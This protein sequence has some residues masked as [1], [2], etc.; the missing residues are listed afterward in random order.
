MAILGLVVEYNPF[1]LGHLYQLRAAKDLLQPR[2]TVAAITGNFTQRGEPA[3]VDKWTRAQMALAQGV[4]LIIEIP[5]AW[6][7]ASASTFAAGAMHLLAAAGATDIHFGSE[8]GRLPPLMAIANTLLTEPPLYRRALKGA[9][10]QGHSFA[11]A[12]GFAL[13]AADQSLD[14][15]IFKEPNNTLGIEYLRAIKE[16]NLPLRAH[17]I[18]RT[19]SYHSLDTSSPVLAATA[20]R[21]NL[22]AGGSSKG[23][24]AQALAQIQKSFKAGRGPI[25]WEQLAPA[26]FYRLRSLPMNAYA[27]WPGA[28]EGLGLRLYKMARR[29]ES[30]QQLMQMVKTRRFP[31]TRI[32]RLCTHVLL[33]LDR[34]KLNAL[35]VEMAPPYL[36]VLALN[37]GNAALRAA[38]K[39][40]SLPVIFSPKAAPAQGK[41]LQ[42]CQA[43]DIYA[44]DIYVLAWSKPGPAG[45]DYTTA[46]ITR[47]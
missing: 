47:S 33:G 10:G 30:W 5:V 29:A 17:T 27:Q 12:Q 15:A 6:A 25:A 46:L 20:I 26:L 23:M 34:A 13:R 2:A 3:I 9:L 16:H 43:L 35:N 36:R 7:T 37:T 18:R 21:R 44:S 42:L 22:F 32:Q 19:T 41:R 38:L 1:H 39:K 24:P 8:A 31:L 45:L 11:A 40:S 28:N 4:D 14:A